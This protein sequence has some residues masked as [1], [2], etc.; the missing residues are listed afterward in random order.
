MLRGIHALAKVRTL[1][2]QR[3]EELRGRLLQVSD[4]A[5]GQLVRVVVQ[6][7]HLL[8]CASEVSNHAHMH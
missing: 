7:D 2:H 3:R 5:E 1:V 4:V 8:A 6:R